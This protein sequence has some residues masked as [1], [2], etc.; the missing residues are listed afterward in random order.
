MYTTQHDYH[1]IF[2]KKVNKTD[3]AESETTTTNNV[4]TQLDRNYQLVQQ[5]STRYLTI[6]GR[7]NSIVEVRDF[8]DC[9]G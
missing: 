9:L 2:N 1:N 4:L 8:V 3:L 5:T 7:G 6:T